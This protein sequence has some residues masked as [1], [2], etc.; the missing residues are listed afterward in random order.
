MLAM[1]ESFPSGSTHRLEN[2]SPGQRAWFI[3]LSE[4]SAFAR[5]A[6]A[7]LVYYQGETRLAI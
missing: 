4:N 3:A 6:D 7:V 5:I 2:M 1:V